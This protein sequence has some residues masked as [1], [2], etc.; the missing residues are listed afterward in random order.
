MLVAPLE[1]ATVAE[2]S[3]ATSVSP[4]VTPAY[5]GYGSTAVGA[6]GFEGLLAEE[7]DQAPRPIASISKVVTALVVLDARPLAGSEQG[8]TITLGSADTALYS[9]YQSVGG[10]VEPMR[11]GWAFTQREMLQVM[12]VSSANNYAELL[13][14][15]AFG[16]QDA[17]VAATAAWLSENGLTATTITEPTGMSPLNVSSASDLVR[18]GMLALEHPVVADIVGTSTVDLP[19]VG[20]IE[21]GNDLIGVGGV[22]GIKTGTLD[23]AGA[24]LLFATDVEVGGRTITVVGVVLGGEDHDTLD[25]AVRSLLDSVEAGFREVRLASAGEVFADY[26]TDWGSTAD[27]VAAEDVSI[28]VWSDTPVSV[29]IRPKPLETGEQG[30]DAGRVRFSVGDQTASVDLELSGSLDGP[31]AWWRLSH[32]LELISP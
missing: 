1:V 27:A 14:G 3:V 10:K 20:T 8:E 6:V 7:G 4:A 2:A 21:N 12:L 30:D 28:V 19:G 13:A 11:A 25:V 23:E 32:P 18:L 24:C 9:K 16:S 17:F 31:D 29:D 15:W 22:D 5:P 26:S